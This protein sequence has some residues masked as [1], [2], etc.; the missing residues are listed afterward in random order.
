MFHRAGLR[1]GTKLVIFR[2][3]PQLLSVAQKEKEPQ[4]KEIQ[5]PSLLEK[6]ADFVKISHTVFALPFALSATVLAA[7]AGHAARIEN[8]ETASAAME[9]GWLHGR[10]H[11]RTGAPLA[12]KHLE[13]PPG[14]LVCF[15]AH[16]PHF[17]SPRKA[18]A[19]TRWGLLLSYRE[20]DPTGRLRSISRRL[21]DGWVGTLPA[22]RRALFREF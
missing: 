1:S 8:G 18:G 16:M 12:I 3:I 11:P 15:P 9:R 19:G 7:R 10:A 4:P 6:W 2:L 13:L 5:K 20:P 17:V 22:P 14:S 21:P